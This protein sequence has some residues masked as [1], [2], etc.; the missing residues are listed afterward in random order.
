MLGKRR[1]DPFCGATTGWFANAFASQFTTDQAM[2]DCQKSI[3]SQ[4]TG[5]NRDIA[6]LDPIAS[7]FQSQTIANF[8][9]GKDDSQFGS[10]P[11]SKLRNSIHQVATGIGISKSDQPK[12]KFELNWLNRQFVF[13]LLLTNDTISGSRLWCPRN[14]VVG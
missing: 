5:C 1:F 12:A 8:D 14:G 2:I 4:F 10:D 7:I 6:K 13:G 9:F 11:I 3:C